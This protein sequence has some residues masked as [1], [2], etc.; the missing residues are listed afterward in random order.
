MTL[1]ESVGLMKDISLDHFL[2]FLNRKEILH[3]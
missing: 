3:T 1:L 2:Q